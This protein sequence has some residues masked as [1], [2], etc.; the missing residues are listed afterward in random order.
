VGLGRF[1]LIDQLKR[2]LVPLFFLPFWVYIQN[3]PE[4]PAYQTG[5]ADIMQIDTL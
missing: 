3:N 4:L 5:P 1:D 2:G